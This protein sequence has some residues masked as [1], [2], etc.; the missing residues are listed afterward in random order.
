MIGIVLD[1]RDVRD[2]K[3]TWPLSLGPL[4]LG[5]QI[6]SDKGS[7]EDSVDRAQQRQWLAP[8]T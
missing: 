5:K 6:G 8:P 2:A 1:P 4:K 7:A 3:Q